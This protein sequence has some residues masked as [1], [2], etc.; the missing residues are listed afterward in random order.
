MVESSPDVE[1]WGGRQRGRGLRI[2]VPFPAS[3]QGEESVTARAMGCLDQADGLRNRSRGTAR[4]KKPKKS[5]CATLRRW[6]K[7]GSALDGSM[8]FCSDM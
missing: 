4:Q 7:Q 2:T 6:E 1:P 3:R 8:L 5:G